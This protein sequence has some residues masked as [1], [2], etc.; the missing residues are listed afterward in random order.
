MAAQLG[1]QMGTRA[2]GRDVDGDDG[3]CFIHQANA[4][5]TSGLASPR[6]RI[7]SFAPCRSANS[8]VYSGAGLGDWATATSTNALDA[9]GTPWPIPTRC[10]SL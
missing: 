4:D 6:H 9:D 3:D 1:K 5:N 7:V 8:S 2:V 10:F